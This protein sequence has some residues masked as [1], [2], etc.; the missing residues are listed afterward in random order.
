MAT[1]EFSG[2]L[3]YC[4]HS[5]DKEVRDASFISARAAQ[6][7]DLVCL[8]SLSI[9]KLKGV[10]TA[11]PLTACDAACSFAIGQIGPAPT[12]AAMAAFLT[13]GVVW[14]YQQAGWGVTRVLPTPVFYFNGSGKAT[15]LPVLMDSL[16][17]SI[18]SITPTLMSS[19]TM[20]WTGCLFLRQ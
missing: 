5:V 3:G 1:N 18:T 17:A 7:G 8:D 15:A 20:P 6:P 11:R 12:A 16:A 19:A 2:H 10:G 9:G 4:V 14:T 13:Q